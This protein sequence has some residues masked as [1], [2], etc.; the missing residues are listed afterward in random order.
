MWLENGPPVLREKSV[1][2]YN[3][4]CYY[5]QL[6]NVGKAVPLLRRSF[7]LDSSLRKTAKRDPDLLPILAQL[8]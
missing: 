8:P 4:G 1:F 3:L 6:G 2:Y 5:A 7:E